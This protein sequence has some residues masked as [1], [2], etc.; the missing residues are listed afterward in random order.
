MYAKVFLFNQSSQQLM[1]LFYL[2][3]A[4]SGGSVDKLKNSQHFEA[5]VYDILKLMICFNDLR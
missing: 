4:R 1:L 2:S 3:V 5:E